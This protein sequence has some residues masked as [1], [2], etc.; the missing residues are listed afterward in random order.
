MDSAAR[1]RLAPETPIPEV[2]IPETTDE[3]DRWPL[4]PEHPAGV[5]AGTAEHYARYRPRYSPRMLEVLL[6]QAGADGT[7]VL[8]DLACGTGELAIALH[9]GFREVWA[10]DLEPEMI[11]EGRRQAAARGITSIRWL[12]GRAEDLDAPPGHFSL[13]TVGRAFHRLHKDVIAQRARAWLRP[14]GCLADLGAESGTLYGQ[15]EEWQRIAYEVYRR[16]TAPLRD[17]DGNVP[18]NPAAPGQPRV[19]FLEVV[20]AAGFT[21]LEA[22]RVWTPHAWTADSLTGYFRSL[23]V[24][25][26]AALGDRAAPFAA[27]LRAALLAHDPSG[28]FPELIESW[29]RMARRP[30]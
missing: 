23:S 14:G 18:Q 10:V 24:A 29:Y 9:A 22:H 27:D 20:R 30:Q 15:P 19:S 4:R 11:A 28:S 26:D 21:G 12:A 8:L 3:Q 17:S 5:F 1:Q 2:P 25:S 7:G 6:A 16:W 13:I